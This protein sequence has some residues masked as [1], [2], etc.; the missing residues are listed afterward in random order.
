MTM[1]ARYSVGVDIGGTFTDCVIREAA[2]AL[3]FDKA[4]TTPGNLAEGVLR[5]IEHAAGQWGLSVDALLAST[6]AFKIGTTSPVNRLINRAGAP[7]A[8]LTTKGH[9]EAILIGRVFQKTDGLSEAE[10]VDFRYWGKAEPLVPRWW[11]GG[12]NERIDSFGEV[13]C[14]LS[15]EEVAATVQAFLQQGVEAFAVSFLWSFLNP[16]HEQQ[17]RDVIHDLVPAAFVTLSSEIAP[18]LGEYERTATTMLN[19]YLGP[20]TA[21]DLASLEGLLRDR[22]L[23]SRVFLMQSTGGVVPA[24]DAMRRP[25]HLLA[26]GPV[27]GVAA[28]QASSP[29]MVNGNLITTDMGGTSF[30]VGVIV[31]GEPIARAVSI[32][33][34]Y[35]VLVSAIEVNSIGAGGGSVAALDPVTGI[36]Q[37]GPRSAGSVPGPVCY[38]FGG[39]EPTVTDANAV[40]GRLNP[41]RFFAGRHRLDLEGARR[42]IAERIAQPLGTGAETAAEAILRIVDSRMA[43]LIRKLT[44]E[45]GHDPRTFAIVAYGG[46]GPLHVGSY[47]REIGVET[48]IIP[49]AAST[50]S[51]WGIAHSP[52]VQHYA[53]SA[54]AVLPVDTD[55]VRE[56]FRRLRE[57]AGS[58][59]NRRGSAAERVA[60][61]FVDMR[62]RYQVHELRVPVG[63]DELTH[64][65]L[66]QTLMERFEALY[67]RR[68]GAGST[69][70]T[71]GIEVATFRLVV[72]QAFP[73]TEAFVAPGRQAHEP[74]GQREVWLDGAYAALPVYDGDRIGPRFEAQG[75]CVLEG[76][77][78]TILVHPAQTIRMDPA[79][80]FVLAVGA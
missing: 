24:A 7:T 42:A 46:G 75:P 13:V 36:L 10:R 52:V 8:L 20:G 79:G 68:F 34:R 22:G 58:G 27:G 67:E 18:V 33:N 64:A 4:F 60:T 76:D 41:E 53:V 35:R 9:E 72:S 54:P 49:R 30:D 56:V 61:L 70:R 23:R 38:G 78:F 29:G 12:I 55:Y 15:L 66:A 26:S 31:Q 16:S 47:G 48:A 2:G 25:V 74:V 73:Y 40:L 63:E 3:V 14:P 45:R 19:S 17:A 77:L 28:A 59:E 57:S 39:T 69:L 5:C 32:H 37:V 50:Y 11:I 62:Y 80:N 21:A 44:I 43:D 71:A 51:A 1:M 6:H 65:G